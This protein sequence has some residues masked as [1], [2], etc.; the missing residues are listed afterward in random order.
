MR[1]AGAGVGVRVGKGVKVG[2]RVGV[3]RRVGTSVN[4]KL[5]PMLMTTIRLIIHSMMRFR[6]DFERRTVPPE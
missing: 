6:R 3:T 1:H 5:S 4:A 2:T